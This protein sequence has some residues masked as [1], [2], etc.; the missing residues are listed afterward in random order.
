MGNTAST[1]CSELSRWDFTA[2]DML[3]DQME[4]QTC[5][6]ATP[7]WMEVITSYLALVLSTM[8]ALLMGS[9]SGSLDQPKRAPTLVD[10]ACQTEDEYFFAELTVNRDWQ[11][12]HVPCKE[13]TDDDNHS[14]TT[15][16]TELFTDAENEELERDFSDDD[17]DWENENS[18]NEDMLHAICDACES[19]TDCDCE[20][21]A[22]QLLQLTSLVCTNNDSLS[23][24]YLEDY[25]C[26]C[27]ECPQYKV[28]A[29]DVVG[30]TKSSQRQTQS[31]TRLLQAFSTY[32]EV[33]GYRAD[34]IPAAR[35]CLRIWCG[36]E[37]KA[38]KSFVTLF[39]EVP[40]LCD[41]ACSS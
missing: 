28:I 34:M 3:L 27:G 15:E 26:T 29:H 38:F 13:V 22:E 2:S 6:V 36:D 39:D 32:N 23:P 1:T 31:I 41:P 17:S 10:A 5:V 12:C 8:A 24:I 40:R 18:E 14:C 21:Q 19:C 16:A 9:F 11:L 25:L 20:T 37:D 30:A 33:L 7:T 4:K 35:E